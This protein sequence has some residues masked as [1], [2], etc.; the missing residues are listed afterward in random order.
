M[1]AEMNAVTIDDYGVPDTYKLSKVA[2]PTLTDKT[3]ILIKVHAASINPIDT[4]KAGGAMKALKKDSFPYVIGY[5]ASGVVEEVAADVKNFKVGDE[6]Y[7]RLPEMDRGAWAEYAKTQE[8]FVALKPKNLSL[9]DSASVPLA[10]MTALQALHRYNGS[11]EGKTVFVPGG[12]GGT[13]AA[14]C[15]LAK[16]VFKAG[17]VITTV[18]T[19]KVPKIPELLGEG[20][21]DEIIDYTKQDVKT[22][23]PAKSIDFYFDT[24]GQSMGHLGL[25]NKD[26]TIVS[27][28][29]VPSGTTMQTAFARQT[30]DGEPVPK[31]PFAI[32][33]FLDATDAVSRF[34]AKRAGAAYEFL[35]L[36]ENAADLEELRGYIEE[37]KLKPVIGAKIN[38]L[39]DFDKVKQA[40][41]Q[42]NKG[43]GALGKTLFVVVPE[44]AP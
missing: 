41:D 22:A 29:S 14:A 12:L 5:D 25:M 15:Q 16:N 18:S 17:K 33:L 31:V 34:R 37:G 21:V 23:I 4:K 39:T 27:V 36:A 43:K 42:T 10:T 32:K 44:A 19:A 1:A 35:F 38:M 40:A 20:V 11:L 30:R 28:A 6:V 7:V 3:D 13:G 2:K 9:V 26:S 8:K 24:M